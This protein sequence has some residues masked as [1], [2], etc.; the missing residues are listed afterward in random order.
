LTLTDGS[1]APELTGDDIYLNGWTARDLGASVGDAVEMSYYVV[2]AGLFRSRS[3]R[4][5][6]VHF[7]G[8][9]TKVGTL[10][11]VRIVEANK[12]SLAGEIVGVVSTPP[13]SQAPRRLNVV[14]A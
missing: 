2:G 13:K 6:I 7:L 1:P 3:E 4:N 14:D 8:P 12:N 10:V 5:E 9:S 11:D